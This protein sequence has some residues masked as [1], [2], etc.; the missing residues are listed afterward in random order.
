MTIEMGPNRYGKARIRLVKVDRL[1]DRHVVRDLTVRIGLEGD[2][3]AAHVSGD[4]AEIIATDTMKNTVYALA[5]EGLTGSIE[6]FG[7]LL[8]DHF[9]L[10]R[11]VHLATVWIQ[12]HAWDPIM[13]EGT[14]APD[15]FVRGGSFTRTAV[16]AAEASGVTVEAGVEEL[17]VMKTGRSAFAGFPRDRYTTLADTGDRIMA[18]KVTATWR[19]GADKTDIDHDATF[20]RTLATLLATFADHMS[21]SVQHSIWIIGKAILEAEPTIDEIRFALPNLHHWTADLSPFGID[22]DRQIFVSTTE[23]HGLI[24]ATVRRTA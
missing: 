9:L 11:Q 13:T 6:A 20:A 2:F 3:A 12:E 19:Y 16:V 21:L 10:H 1:A 8:A 18:T 14:P 23:P 15:A 22:N 4:N 17:T 5:K 24:E 7:T